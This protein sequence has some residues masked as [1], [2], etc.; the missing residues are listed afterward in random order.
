MQENSENSRNR[1]IEI[2]RGQ[3]DS[4]REISESGWVIRRMGSWGEGILRA[5]RS[6]GWRGR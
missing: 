6:L 5:R 2:A 4:K 3:G 1:A